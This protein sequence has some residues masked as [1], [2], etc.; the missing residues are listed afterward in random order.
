MLVNNDDNAGALV[1]FFWTLWGIVQVPTR[2]LVEPNC[3][4]HNMLA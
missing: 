2:P 1:G 3:Y 4:D